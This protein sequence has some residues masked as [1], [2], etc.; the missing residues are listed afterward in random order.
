MAMQ[1]Y[2]IAEIADIATTM[3]ESIQLQPKPVQI[4]VLMGSLST[5]IKHAMESGPVPDAVA[6]LVPILDEQM[7]HGLRAFEEVGVNIGEVM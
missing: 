2:T 6:A 3:F 1:K 7:I 5:L 4:V